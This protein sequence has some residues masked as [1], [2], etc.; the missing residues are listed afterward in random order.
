MRIVGRRAVLR[1]AASAAGAA[2][3]ALPA[4]L[5]SATAHAAARPDLGP[6]VVQLGWVKNVEWAGEYFADQQG[7]YR[8]EGFSGATLTSGGPNAP[9]LES[10][11]HSGKALTA[12]GSPS[13]TAAAI[14]RGAR[15]KI[16][17]VQYQTCPYVIA[18]RAEK[19]LR[20]PQDM[21]G[22]RIGVPSSNEST[23]SAFLKANDIAAG[24]V[25]A[26]TVGFSPAP[27]VT[28]QVD[29]L[30]GFVTNV[31]GALKSRQ[32]GAH[33]F[34]LGEF[35]Y[36]LVNNDY[37]V[38]E[39]ALA[40]RRPALKALLRAEIRGWTRSLAS[41]EQSARLTVEEYGKDL[42]LDLADQI[43]QS[44]IQNRLI[45]SAHTRQHG[46]FTLTP[47]QVEKS[48]ELLRLG[49][50]GISATQLFDLSVLNEVY[51]EDASLRPPA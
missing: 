42:G 46:L 50:I 25:Q 35:N 40:K 10:V 41:P 17:A 47:E 23:W 7:Y 6:L 43:D 20:T 8:D 22:K 51:A 18:S 38:S 21:I 28:G 14:L 15:L 16:I 29:G 5:R 11:V 37:M 39:D 1:A 33:H 9:P 4:V 34:G 12:I 27:L 19:P 32:I 44:R 2:V 45:Q 13:T 36:P 49:G 31:L 24:R 3:F 26:V 48:V 30:L